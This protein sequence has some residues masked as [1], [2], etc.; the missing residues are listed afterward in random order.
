MLKIK[1]KMKRVYS[2]MS[3]ILLLT[4]LVA[5]ENAPTRREELLVQYPDWNSKTIKL[6]RDGKIFIGMTKD[7]V[8]ASWGRHCLTCQGTTE[9]TWGESWE[10][11]TQVVFFDSEGKV[12]RLATK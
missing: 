3:L 5:C 1:D 10:Y 2:V 4:T 7:Q 9:G 11:A 12:V 6:I 8:R